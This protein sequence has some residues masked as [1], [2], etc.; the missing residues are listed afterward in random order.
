MPHQVRQ[1]MEAR[2]DRPEQVRTRIESVNES[3]ARLRAERLRLLARA[4][5][6]AR[7]RDT[8]Q[9]IVIGGAVLTAVLLEGVPP[10][11]NS[12]ELLAWLERRL[13]RPYDRA[14]FDFKEPRR[15]DGER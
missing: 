13:T 3:L 11:R 6:A 14:A 12:D 5:L 1:H 4:T 8:R 9:K 10:L 2:M 7:K 15:A